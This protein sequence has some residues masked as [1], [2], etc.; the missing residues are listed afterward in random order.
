[1]RGE[2]PLPTAAAAAAVA[3]VAGPLTCSIAFL[4]AQSDAWTPPYRMLLTP[5]RALPFVQAADRRLGYVPGEALLKF[6]PGVGVG[7]QELGLT[8]LPNPPTPIRLRWG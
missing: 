1:M 7:G 8:A 4:S 3:M 6:K 2:R 5:D